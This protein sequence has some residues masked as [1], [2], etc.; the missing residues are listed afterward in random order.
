MAQLIALILLIV[1]GLVLYGR[2]VKAA[3]KLTAQSRQRRREEQTGAQGT[4]TQ[5]PVTGEYRVKRADEEEER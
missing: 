2:F 5:D 1:G 4:L 3:E